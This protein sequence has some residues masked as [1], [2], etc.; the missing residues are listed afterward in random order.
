MSYNK[1]LLQ[2]AETTLEMTKCEYELALVEAGLKYG[3][4]VKLQDQLNVF[5]FR[6]FR[7]VREIESMQGKV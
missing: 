7:L 2:L 3:D 4:P 6:V 1:K 5:K